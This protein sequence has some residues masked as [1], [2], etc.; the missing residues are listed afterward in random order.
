MSGSYGGAMLGIAVAKDNPQLAEALKAAVQ[1]LMDE[2]A[3]KSI[4]TKW[5]LFQ[6]N[7]ADKAGINGATT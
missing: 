1:K 6:F 3:Y 7:S 4:L 5:G 2:G